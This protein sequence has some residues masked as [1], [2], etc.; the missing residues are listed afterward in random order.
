MRYIVVE[1]GSSGCTWRGS[2]VSL[3]EVREGRGAR[4]QGEAPELQG[5][6]HK[7]TLRFCQKI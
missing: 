7:D 4:E 3:R 6:G 1:V 2:L 5:L